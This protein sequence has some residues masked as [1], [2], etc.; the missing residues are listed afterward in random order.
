M[1]APHLAV[2]VFNPEEVR[3][4]VAGGADMIDC[5]DPR[6]DL[7]MFE[8][9]VVTSAA[10]AIRQCETSKII[11][12]SANIG[13]SLQLVERQ[14]RGMALPR[15]D[16]EI[17]AKAAQETLGL[18]AAMDVGD[19]RPNIIKFEV[20]GL[21]KEQIG[22][23]VT[24]VKNAIAGS[25][26]Y[27]NHRAIG[28]FLVI[29]GDEWAR[30][31]TDS[32]V[33]RPLLDL[34]QFYFTP[35]GSIDLS[36]Y[37]EA[38]K[39]KKF[40]ERVSS[41]ST[42]GYSTVEL[43]DPFDPASLAMPADLEERMRTYVDLISQAGADGVLIDTPMQAKC[44]RICL[45]KHEKN[46]T[47]NG[48]GQKLP[49]YGIFDVKM[50]KRFADYCAYKNVEAWLAGSIQSYHAQVLGKID[51]LDVVLCR[52]SA[53]DVVKSPYDSSVSQS[54]ER[55]DRRITREKVELMV[56]SLKDPTGLPVGSK[57]K[58]SHS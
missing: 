58:M 9:R 14:D 11:P 5:E 55:N 6:S 56:K 21:R 35:T 31:K 34:G 23:L 50:L 13:F 16:I 54:D 1:A 24:A 22:P 8:P 40:Q 49:R 7:G 41:G 47:D 30:R 32:R 39:V 51:S 33:I 19:S 12:T 20:D 57:L 17:Q 4:A 3:A 37:Y 38:E 18:A 45:V 48:G 46:I 42:I 25:Y 53:S 44:S 43:I 29:D 28:S 15:S 36:K 52:D 27:Q 2:S 10:F 26:R